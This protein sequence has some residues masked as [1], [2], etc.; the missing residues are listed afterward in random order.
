MSSIRRNVHIAAPSRAVWNAVTTAE[1][2]SSW[3][4]D[5]ARVDGRQGGRLVLGWTDESG[6][7]VEARGMF[8]EFRP[9]A[10][11]EVLFDR[12]GS[13]PLKGCRL[14]LQVA[15]DGAETRL[16]LLLADGEALQDPAQ[17]EALDA[18][19]RRDLK[20]LQ[21]LLDAPAPAPAPA[22]PRRF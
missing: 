21:D 15:R 2:L 6:A 18:G 4:V 3:W 13:S 22:A 7:D 8:H 16:T 5:N 14:V 9:T 11:V 1:G 17:R 10:Q 20:A 12:V 19:W